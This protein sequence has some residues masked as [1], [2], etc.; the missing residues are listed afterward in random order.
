[1]CIQIHFPLFPSATLQFFYELVSMIYQKV[2]G[3]QEGN[4]EIQVRLARIKNFTLSN[5]THKMG[6]LC[7]PLF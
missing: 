4:R 1:M 2:I 3:D 5:A 6:A 7:R